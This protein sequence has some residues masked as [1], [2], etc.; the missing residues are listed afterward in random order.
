MRTK[1]G[2]RFSSTNSRFTYDLGPL[3]NARPVIAKMHAIEKQ[4]VNFAGATTMAPK[5]NN[6]RNMKN[7]D[8][9]IQIA[10]HIKLFSL[11]MKLKMAS[12]P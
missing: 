9:P 5:S 10:P 6:E 4:V 1:D 11:L 3:R 7:P 8:A 12:Q 2:I